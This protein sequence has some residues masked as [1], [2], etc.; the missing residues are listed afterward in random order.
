MSSSSDLGKAVV[1]GGGAWGAR[2][3]H[4]LHEL[5]A[6][7]GVCETVEARRS[8]LGVKYSDVPLYRSLS[9]LTAQQPGPAVV[10][11]PAGTHHAVARKLMLAG[12][13]V[14]VEKPMT[15][16]SADARDLVEVA[17]EHGRI[18][19]VGHLL[20]YTP[21]VE[22]LTSRLGELGA[23]RYLRARRLG[24]GRVRREE[25]VLWS[26]APHDIALILHFI[27]E[28]PESVSCTGGAYVQPTI[29]DVA[30]LQMRFPSGRLASIQVS[31]LEPER[32]RGL[33][34]VGERG[35]AV[36]DEMSA[37][38]PLT[39]V[40][41]EVDPTT[42]HATSHDMERPMVEATPP[43]KRECTHFLECVRNRTTPRS[44]GE[45]GLAVVHILECATQSLHL[46]GDWIKVEHGQL[47]SRVGTSR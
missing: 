31:W 44:P 1:V 25:N 21:A 45:Q 24:L 41:Q 33:K 17:E 6:L 38:Q 15:L 37:S 9:E 32:S 7:G 43:L 46:G 39:M 3:I 27:D 2:W 5:G 23:L 19:M 36:L 22:L 40:R 42:L 35:S 12:F 13:D 26:F 16:N 14:M 29:E 11:T 18:L 47:R 34:I 28:M 8:E 4:T 20:L 10:A 30:F